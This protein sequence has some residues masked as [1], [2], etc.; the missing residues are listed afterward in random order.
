MHK[1]TRMLLI[2]SSLMG[3]SQLVYA[4]VAYRGEFTADLWR[5][6][7]KVDNTRHETVTTPSF[8]LSLEHQI[9]WVPNVSI[10][11]TS[12][13]ADNMKLDKYDYTLYYPLIEN[14]RLS[15]DGGI[16][17]SQYNNTLYRAKRGTVYDFDKWTWNWYSRG[18]IATPIT[19]LD[20]IGQFSFSDNND[21][22]AA[23]VLAGVR[24]H[25]SVEKMKLT[26]R[27]GYRVIDLELS[28]QKSKY[29]NYGL[30]FAD[31]FFAGV[32]IGF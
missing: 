22:H 8:D 31:G 13:D 16:T 7:T 27:A 1:L 10:R 28:E 12:L 29:H 18:V 23:D 26:L 21:I 30:V 3:I 11:Y 9:D 2:T 14:K 32:Q 25:F 20:I 24:Y 17:F 4:D 5:S 15:L 19:G 6:R